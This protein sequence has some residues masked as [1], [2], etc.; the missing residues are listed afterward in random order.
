MNGHC[1]S[2]EVLFESVAKVAGANAVGII[3][4][5][6]GGDGAKG[7]VV[8]AKG[9]GKDHRSGRVDLCGLRYA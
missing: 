7:A 1:P 2:V 9:R 4:T 5:G 8:H 3:L 6:M